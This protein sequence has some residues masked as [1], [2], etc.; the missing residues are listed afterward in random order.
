M[1]VK[2][3]TTSSGDGIAKAGDSSVKT[4]TP[5]AQTLTRAPVP[6]LTRQPL[7]AITPVP[8]GYGSFYSV[9]IASQQPALLTFCFKSAVR[10]ELSTKWGRV[11]EKLMISNQVLRY[12]VNKSRQARGCC[13]AYHA[14]SRS[15]PQNS[16]IL[17]SFCEK[18]LNLW[19]DNST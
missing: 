4:K 8:L 6:W 5:A 12:L 18:C 10:A 14:S 3:P 13:R 2:D 11:V 17:R 1:L 16:R 19:L 7:N 9:R 15:I